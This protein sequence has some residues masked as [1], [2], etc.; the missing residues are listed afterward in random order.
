MR[1]PPQIQKDFLY[2]LWQNRIKKKPARGSFY[3]KYS[4][5]QE[6]ISSFVVGGAGSEYGLPMAVITNQ[7][8]IA[9]Q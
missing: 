5:N 7:G 8:Q 3:M 4:V 6:R 9:Y 1:K 2:S